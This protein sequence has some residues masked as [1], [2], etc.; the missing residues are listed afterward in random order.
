MKTNTPKSVKPTNKK[1]RKYRPRIYIE[2]RNA[3]ILRRLKNGEAPKEIT[4]KLGLTSVWVVYDAIRKTNTIN[5]KT[6]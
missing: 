2:K 5:S 1:R 3:E 6:S 4:Y